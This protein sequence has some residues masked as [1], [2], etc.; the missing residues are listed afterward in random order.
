MIIDTKI[1]RRLLV[2]VARKAT[3]E[4]MEILSDNVMNLCD[5]YDHLA[6]MERI[7]QAGENSLDHSFQMI[8]KLR[9]SL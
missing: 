2:K 6:S 4:N 5:A 3:D 9:K 1:I 8:E 7:I